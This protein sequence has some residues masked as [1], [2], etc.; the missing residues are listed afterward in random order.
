MALRHDIRRG[1]L[2]MLAAHALFTSMGAIVKSLAETVPVIELMFFR[3][4][5]ALPVV[6]LICARSGGATLRTK[7][8]GGHA[9][10]ACTG[11]AAQ[12]LGFYAL[13]VLPLAEQVAL[14]Y[15]QPLFVT[16]LAIPFLG[17]KVGLHRWSAVVLGFC[18]VLLI[19]AGQGVGFGAVSP[20]LV[21]GTVAGVAQ[22][23]FSALTTLL[24][25]QLSATESST[26]ITL[27]QSLLMGAYAALLLPF[28]WVTPG[29]TE[30]GLLVLVGLVGGS[31]QWLLTEAWASAQVSAVAPY[32]Y[33]ALL[34][35][36][37][38]GWMVFG[39]LPGVA[40]LGG[41]ALIVVAGLY[42]LHRELVRKGKR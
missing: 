28:V 37:G 26:T 25:R 14:G 1:A 35:S 9:L 4:A 38:L 42:I 7:R 36:I 32:S 16:I 11:I 33:S 41:S 3:S 5:F 2:C 17:E 8:F 23:M 22:G 39:D 29:W 27:W 12:T 30:L 34:W 18:G 40:M 13:G 15:T 31:A 19:A 21:K 6:L 10:R 20:E 24:V